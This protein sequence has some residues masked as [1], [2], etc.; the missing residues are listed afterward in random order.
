M[1]TISRPI[2]LW[3]AAACLPGLPWTVIAGKP[4]WDGGIVSNSPFDL[5]ID[6]C[7]PD[8][9]R[10]FIVDLFVGQ[11]AL[12]SN[13]M[14]V[15]ARRDEIVY[16]ERIRSDLR[17]RE[18]IN[19]YRRLVDSIL[20]HLEPDEIAKIKQRPGYIQLMGDGASTQHRPDRAPSSRGRTSLPGLR[21]FG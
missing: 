12:P 2:I 8:G 13:M 10:V 3:P 9:K 1:S 20:G 7:G 21:L 6:R 15:L 4:Y 17:Y 19:A 5:L 18:M 14:E 11:R 16:S